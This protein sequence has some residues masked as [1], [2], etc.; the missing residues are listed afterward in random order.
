MGKQRRAYNPAKVKADYEALDGRPRRK[1]PWRRLKLHRRVTVAMLHLLSVLLLSVSFAPFDQ[2]YLAYVALVPWAL[3]LLVGPQQRWG[4]CWSFL[5]GLL[6]WAC[7]LY[8]LWWITLAGYFAMIVY[9]AAYWLLAGWVVRE[10]MKRSWPTWLVLPAVWVALEYARAHVISGFPWLFLAHSQYEQTRLIQVADLTGQYGVSFFVAMVNGVVIDLL[11]RARFFENTARPRAAKSVL[12]GAA[13]TVLVLVALLLY[14]HYRIG[15]EVTEPGPAIGIVQYNFPVSLSHPSA[16]QETVF[17]KHHDMTLERLVRKEATP[18]GPAK[19]CDL[20]LWPESMMPTGINHEFRSL[21]PASL[22]SV[23]LR[24]LSS[25]LFRPEDQRASDEELRR[26]L[27]Y[28]LN[29]CVLDDGRRYDGV[30]TYATLMGKLSLKLGCPII[31]GATTL[32]R[33]PDPVGDSDLWIQQ[34]SALWV[35]QTWLDKAA[36]PS[37]EYSKRHLV[38]FSEHVPFKRSWPWLHRLLRKCVPGVMPQLEPGRD[39]TRF[40]LK[41]ENRTWRLATPICY[42]GTFA[43]VCR[44]MVTEDGRK[45]V[46]ILVNLSNDGWFIYQRPNGQHHSSTELSQHLVHYV[47]RA[48]ENR[49]PVIRAVNTGISASI[50][51]VGRIVATVHHYGL[52]E[53]IAGTLLLSDDRAAQRPHLWENGPRVLVDERQSVYSFIGDVFAM[54]AALAALVIAGGI[55]LKRLPKRQGVKKK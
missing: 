45:A 29:G 40:E 8:W 36:R 31:A 30:R 41:Q 44:D 51:S 24:S 27:D 42:E 52:R 19:I 48:V 28:Q 11:A 4:L 32:H 9:L 21:D 47:F 34:N 35:D 16:S 18:A 17:K 10:S 2:W 7:N 15:Q 5:A 26:Q 43:R 54:S 55:V 25:R 12:S 38:P 14:G 33:N 3:A 23:E 22:N 37:L 46:D 1:P 49:T 20:V 39:H 53:M 6:F 50:D 13:A